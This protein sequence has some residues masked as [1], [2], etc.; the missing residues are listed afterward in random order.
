MAGKRKIQTPIS[1]PEFAAE[2]DLTTTDMERWVTEGS[3]PSCHSTLDDFG[4]DGGVMGGILLVLSPDNKK[5]R[6]GQFFVTGK[7]YEDPCSIKADRLWPEVDPNL[8]FNLRVEEANMFTFDSGTMV[9]D[10]IASENLDWTITTE[11]PGLVAKTLND[12]EMEE[13]GV[14]EFCCRMYAYPVKANWVKISLMVYPLAKE[15]LLEH[16]KLALNKAFPGIEFKG[17]EVKFG[18]VNT[19]K[20]W[21][22]PVIPLLLPGGSVEEY[23]IE[24]TSG[25]ILRKM[26]SVLRTAVKP[27]SSRNMAGLKTKWDALQSAGASRLREKQPDTVWPESGD[28]AGSSSRVQTGRELVGIMRN[29]TNIDNGV[30]LADLSIPSFCCCCHYWQ[31][32]VGGW[33]AIPLD[34]SNFVV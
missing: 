6:N 26:S 29:W 30:L 3:G 17:D 5:V 4:W 27:D 14:G 22:S 23:P 12:S 13:A 9:G 19:E 7:L 34:Y 33:L 25:E 8:R 20:R 1:G 11:S 32:S 18:P 24:I 2:D 31:I 16:H 15:S 21:G 28:R 10:Y